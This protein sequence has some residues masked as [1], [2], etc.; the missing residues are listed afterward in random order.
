MDLGHVPQRQQKDLAISV[1]DGGRQVG[2]G[3]AR[4]GQILI[5]VAFIGPTRS[6]S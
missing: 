6:I 5:E 3:F 2:R 1:L 4:V